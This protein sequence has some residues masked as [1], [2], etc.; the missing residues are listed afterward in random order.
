M[1]VRQEA[2]P[3]PRMWVQ[4]NRKWILEQA[5]SGR[6]IMDIGSDPNRIVSS[7]F[8]NMEQNMLRNYQKL[9]P[10]WVKWVKP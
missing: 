9:H 6:T 2:R 3:D 10:E 5:R 1:I 7:I 4:Y 8:Y